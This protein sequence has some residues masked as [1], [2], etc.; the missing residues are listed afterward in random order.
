ML[1]RTIILDT[2]TTGLD[3]AEDRLVELA[4]L[5]FQTDEYYSMICN[6]GRGIPPEAMAIHHITEGMVADAPSPMT[7]THAMLGKLLDHPEKSSVPFFVAH[8]AKFDRGFMA[9]L[10]GAVR[11]VWICTY[12]CAVMTWPDAPR[13][14][15]QVLRYWLGLKCPML[16]L[17]P[18]LSPHRALYDIIVTRE[19]FRTLLTFN[20]VERLIDWSNS[21]IILPK[22]TFG[23]H[24]GKTWDEVDYGY[25]RWCCQ[26]PDMDEDVLFT[27]QH[28][29]RKR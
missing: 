20:P 24:K 9:P 23:K 14:T 26:Q 10:L 1:D 17:I 4:G 2:E 19:I 13:H 11:P 7:V 12:R 22:V 16:D 29:M 3:P 15:N 21:P 8:N 5:K 28:F 18:N 6:P 25:L 27:A